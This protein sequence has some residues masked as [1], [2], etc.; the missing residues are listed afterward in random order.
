MS[1]VS[2]GAGRRRRGTRAWSARRSLAG[3]TGW[4]L[5]APAL[6]LVL[7][8]LVYPLVGVVLRSL[9]PGGSLAYTHPSFSTTNYRAVA[10]DPAA[11]IILRNTFVIAAIAAVIAVVVAYPVAAHLSRVR[12]RSAKVLLLLALF[13]F[14]T[15]ILV[16]IY[17]F[18]LILGRMDLLFKEIAVI[19]GM[20]SYLLPYLILIFYSG[21][22]RIDDGLL[23]AARTLGATPR[24]SVQKIFVP[25]TRP[26]V[27]SGT[28]LVFIIGLGFF[29]TPALLGGPSNLTVAMYIQ[30]QVN[31]GTWGDAS[32]MGVG[33]LVVALVVYYI[34]DRFFGLERVAGGGNRG[35]TQI[36][37]EDTSGAPW[38]TRKT[39]LGLGT[40]TTLVFVFLIAPLIYV[41]LVS[42]SA[43]SYL[44]FPPKSFST[45]WYQ[46]LFD[47]PAW[48]QAAWLS[49]RV[50]VLTTVL[51]TAIG[52]LAALGMTRH[53]LR[54]S[55]LLRALFMLPMIVPVILIA[56]GV[57]DL[58]TR[59]SLIGSVR[60][61]ALAHTML[62][63]PFSIII[64]SSALQQVGSSLEEAARSMGA[65]PIRAFVTVTLPLILPSLLAS[66]AIAFVTSWDEAVVSLFLQVVEPTMPVAIYQFVQQDL[67]PTVAALSSLILGG[68]LLIGLASLLVG[69]VTRR[70][71]LKSTQRAAAALGR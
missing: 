12:P 70:R 37:V 8:L 28:L 57:Y 61:Y 69:R 2:A 65:G 42:F 43:K 62:A 19:V 34:F 17:A 31:Q 20:V 45:R 5:V 38:A 67:R 46:E 35:P 33:L 71:R 3:L 64:I 53:R 54:G 50:A 41:V 49:L 52:L 47:D 1:V 36:R 48:R 16:R 4:A 56:A 39:R 25:L 30:Q 10:D 27:Y 66:A 32:A 9:D 23:R 58:E 44:T 14:W 7:V 55:G 40:W 11:R 18:Q 13:P 51:T 63:L 29:L 68:L 59:I 15:S 60:G 6:V 22:V 26:V 24:Q 21:M